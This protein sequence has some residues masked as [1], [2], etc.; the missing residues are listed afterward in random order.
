MRS[1][2][3]RSVDL[4]LRGTDQMHRLIGPEPVPLSCLCPHAL[5]I[6]AGRQVLGPAVLERDIAD[7]PAFGGTAVLRA[8]PLSGVRDLQVAL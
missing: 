1:S 8:E 5:Q 6:A 4:R 7:L 3:D 2:I